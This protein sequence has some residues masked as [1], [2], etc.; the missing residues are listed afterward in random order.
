M[1]QDI[2]EV[3]ASR[4][5][6][7]HARQDRASAVSRRVSASRAPPPGEMSLVGVGDR[8]YGFLRQPLSRPTR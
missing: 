3:G 6:A 1:S 8:R 5:G 2:E 7:F 4:S